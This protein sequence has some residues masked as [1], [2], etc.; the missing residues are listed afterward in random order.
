[1]KIPL[2]IPLFDTVLNLKIDYATA[3]HPFM[4]DFAAAIS[5]LKEYDSN[6]TT[7]NSY[8]REIERLLQWS[9]LICKQSIFNLKREDIEN[10]LAFCQ[11]P[12]LSWIGKAKVPRFIDSDHTRIPNPTWRPFVA[13]VTK[14]EMRMGKRPDVEQYKLSEKAVREIFAVLSSFYNFSIQEKYTETNP[15]LQIRQKNKYFRKRQRAMVVRRL[16]ELQW[17]TVIET[18]QQLAQTNP[19]RHERTLFIMSILYGMY[20]RI[21]ELVASDRWLP[22]MSDFRRN[23][24]GHWWFTTV[25]KG[26]KERQIAVSDSLLQALKRWRMYLNLSPLPGIDDQS[27]L[28]PKVKGK[29]PVTSTNQIRNI[30]QYCFDQAI[31]RLK[32]DGLVEEAMGL[33]SAT[34]HWLRH[35][36]ISDD[37][38]MR[39]REHVRD[40]AGH[41][42]SATTDKYIDIDLRERYAS[43]RKKIINKDTHS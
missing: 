10:Y 35:T 21:S 3:A 28:I 11:K 31:M 16:T 19:D 29:G 26:N 32:N 41:S 18:A 2:P 7:F 15:L 8:R 24:D 5:F 4:S 14:S 20:L 25:G 39:P 17:D 34:V 9:W 13:T 12:P 36:G 27:P 37:I 23:E 42:S 30:V 40:D 22:K 43:A 33:Q 1:M 6:I 38:K